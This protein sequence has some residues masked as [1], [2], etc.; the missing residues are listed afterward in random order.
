MN[1]IEMTTLDGLLAAL[2]AVG[3]PAFSYVAHRSTERK[4]A[5]GVLIS[6]EKHYRQTLTLLWVPTG[7]LTAVWMLFDRPWLVLGISQDTSFIWTYGSAAA[8]IIFFLCSAQLVVFALRP[9]AASAAF[10][11]IEASPGVVDILPKNSG[12]MWW[13]TALSASAGFAEE[14]MFRGFLIWFLGHW[15]SLPIAA[16]LSLCAFTLAHL[17]QG[18]WQALLKVAVTGLVFTLLTVF[19]GSLWPAIFAHFIVDLTAGLSYRL[20][21]RA[22]AVVEDKQ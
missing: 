12:H 10:E 8:L 20:A 9:E 21:A 15:V 22:E 5:Q 14:L 18:S 4:R 3:I 19:S 11:G 2:I 17:Y 1:E 16:A 13:W 7:F 6:T